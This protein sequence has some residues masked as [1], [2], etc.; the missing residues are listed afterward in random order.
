MRE[1]PPVSIVTPFYNT[2]EFL[3]ECI[4]SVLTQS[5]E[6]WEYLLVNNCSTDGSMEIAARYGIK[7]PRIRV[8]TNSTFLNQVQNYN[9]ALRQISAASR[10]CKMVQADDLIFPDCISKMV[11]LAETDPR[12]GVVSSYSLTG[13]RVINTGLPYDIKIIYGP[14]VCR[15][16]LQA[17]MFLFGS[18]TSVLFRSEIVRQRDPFYREGSPNEDTEACYEIL[19]NWDF[20]F[21]HQILSYLR[22]DNVSISAAVKDHGASYLEKFIMV[23]KYGRLFLGEAEF[24]KC[25]KQIRKVYFEDLALNLLRRQ[26]KRVWEFHR[27]GLHGLGYELNKKELIFPHLLKVILDIALNPKNS[28]ERMLLSRKKKRRGQPVSPS[29]VTE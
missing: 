23:N 1:Q 28:I 3:A 17:Q 29:E 20:G 8:L 9:Q 22:I 27:R 11:A 5:Y 4:E 24:R 25:L 10:Y 26:D 15:K 19:Q 13:N 21:V 2:A 14:E 18:P 16:S 7:D 12:I 6:N